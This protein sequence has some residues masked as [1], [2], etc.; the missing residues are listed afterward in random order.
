[1]RHVK[2]LSRVR[3]AQVSCGLEEDKATRLLSLYVLGKMASNCSK[4]SDLLKGGTGEGEGEA[5]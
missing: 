5:S 2:T 1:M 3:L 4:V